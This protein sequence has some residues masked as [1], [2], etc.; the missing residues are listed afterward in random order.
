MDL[1]PGNTITGKSP[2]PYEGD[3]DYES[4]QRATGSKYW[5]SERSYEGYTLFGSGNAS[6]LID[7]DGD[8]V[9]TWPAGGNPRVLDYTDHAGNILVAD[10][11]DISEFDTIHEMDWSGNT[12]WTYTAPSDYKLHNDF[13]RIYNSSLGDYTTLILANT[14][15]SQEEADAADY[16]GD[17]LSGDESMDVIIEVD[18]SGNIIWEWRFIDHAS[19]TQSDAGKIYLNMP[20]R[21]L[22]SNWLDCN[23]IDYNAAKD[24]IVINSSLGEF[25]VIDHNTTTEEASG[26][27]GDFL[28]R[29]GDPA[30][31]GAGDSPLVET[32]WTKS[33]PGHKQ[34]GATHNV[35]WIPDDSREGAGNFLVFNNGQYLF[36][37]T[38]QNYI[39]E[40]NGYLQSNGSPTGSY[41]D[42]PDA[43]YSSWPQGSDEH[44][45][46]KQTKDLSNQVEWMYYADGNL[47][48]FSVMGGSAQRLPNGNTLICNSD[49]GHI[50]EITYI[51]ESDQTDTSVRRN[52]PDVVWEYISP[53]T[54]TGQ[55]DYVGDNL[56]L[57][58]AVYRA[59]RYPKALF[60]EAMD[61]LTKVVIALQVTAGMN[62]S[63][64]TGVLD[65]NEDSRVGLEEAVYYL[66]S[67]AGL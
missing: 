59:Y 56:D 7:M 43:D 32:D 47:N 11:D 38:P 40:V 18:S 36:E 61:D 62:P 1:T 15:V 22:A 50:F 42:P 10:T 2:S 30:R 21:P 52:Y 23:S 24:Q 66:R 54:A 49:L 45:R 34:I 20:G 39:F 55:K 63:Y 46:H 6:Y 58:N 16:S 25:Y 64:V 14:L 19:N 67:A 37:Y 57:P 13:T 26:L 65:I 48:F 8:T 27:A 33:T 41:V 29:F 12:V 60:P 3:D 9:N 53:Y 31:Y 44:D 5:D 4:L 51:A 17:S 28:Y 35:T